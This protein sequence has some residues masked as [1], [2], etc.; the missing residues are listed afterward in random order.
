MTKTASVIA[1]IEPDIKK[2]AERVLNRLG[3][4]MSNAVGI[5]LRHVVLYNG[6]P[7]EFELKLPRNKPLALGSLNDEALDAEINKGVS[8]VADG[9]T[10]SAREVFDRLR[11]DYTL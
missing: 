8:D 5:F 9:R 11:E 10:A 2:Q 4:P 6:M 3:I 1:R 7:F